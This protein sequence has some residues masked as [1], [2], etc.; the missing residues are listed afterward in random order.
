MVYFQK[1]TVCKQI[2]LLPP[3]TC[4]LLEVQFIVNWNTAKTYLT[5][6]LH[7]FWT[8]HDF[9]WVVCTTCCFHC[10]ISISLTCSILR[11]TYF[12]S[13]FKNAPST[14]KMFSLELNAHTWC[15]TQFRFLLWKYKKHTAWSNWS[16]QSVHLDVPVFDVGARLAKFPL[17]SLPR[18]ESSSL[19]C[20]RQL[21]VLA[22]NT[23][24]KYGWR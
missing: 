3:N 8:L 21:L 4:L 6:I 18:T 5:N 9:Y 24:H 2:F 20:L 14:L 11:A 22:S 19:K 17:S 7:C 15:E 12:I 23:R 13:K 1:V 10:S 16:H